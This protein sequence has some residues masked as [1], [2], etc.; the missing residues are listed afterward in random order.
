MD[1]N[2]QVNNG[3][4]YSSKLDAI[5]AKAYTDW[6]TGLS[7]E[8]IL[9]YLADQQDITAD[10]LRQM[11]GNMNSVLGFDTKFSTRTFDALV[12]FRTDR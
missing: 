7:K 12:D 3:S 4:S 11:I 2:T 6:W 1:E 9:K 5:M 8:E 10:K